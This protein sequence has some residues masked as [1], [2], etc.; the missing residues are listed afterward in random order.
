MKLINRI[1]MKKITLSVL[2]FCC[3]LQG[4][5]AASAASAASADSGA[6]KE[7]AYEDFDTELLRLIQACEENIAS[8]SNPENPHREGLRLFRILKDLDKPEGLLLSNQ[9]HVVTERQGLKRAFKGVYGNKFLD[10]GEE[11]KLFFFYIKL[12]LLKEIRSLDLSCCL[13]YHFT[14]EEKKDLFRLYEILENSKQRAV[15]KIYLEKKKL[16]RD[17]CKNAIISHLFLQEKTNQYFSKRWDKLKSC[18][19]EW[20]SLEKEILADPLGLSGIEPR[21]GLSQEEVEFEKTFRSVFSNI[22][23]DIY[24]LEYKEDSERLLRRNFLRLSEEQ[25]VLFERSQND[26]FYRDL[27]ENGLDTYSQNVEK[28]LRGQTTITRILNDYLSL[29]DSHTKLVFSGFKGN[30]EVEIAV[31]A[32]G[33]SE[34]D[35]QE[36]QESLSESKVSKKS[37][38]ASTK[39][40]KKKG[41]NKKEKSAERMIAEGETV[42]ELDIEP[43][44]AEASS[45]RSKKSKGDSVESE[46]QRCFSGDFSAEYYDR[47]LRWW[48]PDGQN[49][50]SP[51]EVMS[52]KGFRN[53]APLRAEEETVEACQK[54]ENALQLEIYKHALPAV[55]PRML[56]SSLLVDTFSVKNLDQGRSGI[57]G[58]AMIFEVDEYQHKRNLFKGVFRIGYEEMADGSLHV[59]HV[60]LHKGQMRKSNNK[61]KG[62]KKKSSRAGP[63][64]NF[65]SILLKT[66]QF[67]EEDGWT[68]HNP[69]RN[70]LEYEYNQ[71]MK[72]LVFNLNHEGKT[73]Y[74]V[75][76][77]KP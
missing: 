17:L 18:P 60:D 20:K 40:R 36:I 42:S 38:S 66:P 41:R 35:F 39:K 9:S 24:S 11:E 44:C 32:S 72:A 50:V 57:S 15:Y 34:R 31:L 8:D 45:A 47:V 12:R 62:K 65:K 67:L 10:R 69:S 25:R 37:G 13:F 68:F 19:T 71:E 76:S 14:F 26:P 30:S 58:S 23:E 46:C 4:L 3:S 59:Y 53:F 16:P 28:E 73:L 49:L 48:S 29:V 75:V 6:S 54:R 74:L 5:Q 61:G 56:Q 22:L 21:N 1:L 64:M 77:E 33:L 7:V 63:R 55:L 70:L 43:S 27:Y 52:W 51:K 2:L